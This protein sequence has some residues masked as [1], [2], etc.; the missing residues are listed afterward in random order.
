[1]SHE[2]RLAAALVK[3]QNTVPHY[4]FRHLTC[5]DLSASIKSKQRFSA[6]GQWAEEWNGGLDCKSQ[7]RRKKS[8]G[9]ADLCGQ[10]LKLEKNLLSGRMK[11]ARAHHR[12]QA[13]SES[14]WVKT[15]HDETKKM[16]S[17]KRLNLATLADGE[18][19]NQGPT[20]T[21]RSWTQY[22]ELILHHD[23]Q[24]RQN[25]TR[26][27]NRLRRLT[28]HTG[29]KSTHAPKDSDTGTKVEHET[30]RTEQRPNIEARQN[31]DPVKNQ[32]GKTNNTHKI[33]N[34]FFHWNS[35]I[36]GTILPPSF[37]Y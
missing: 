2:N 28:L 32:K 13:A 8:P 31:S 22:A 20:V 6:P 11:A 24:R 33:K 19:R 18:N 25:Q 3:N 10:N 29:G 27:P 14:G 9:G 12:R 16:R 34:W 7:Q 26:K 1:M 15:L 21:V 17:E 5:I 36:E 35:N 30:S 37:D 23:E 4:N